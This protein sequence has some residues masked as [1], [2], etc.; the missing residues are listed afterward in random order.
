MRVRGKIVNLYQVKKMLDINSIKET[1]EMLKED[2]NN[3]DKDTR[4]YK[5][6]TFEEYLSY[7]RNH[8]ANIMGMEEFF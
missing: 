4:K 7:K 1:E 3:I 2:Y 6:L 8:I 5:G